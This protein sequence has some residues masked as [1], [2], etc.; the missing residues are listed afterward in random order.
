MSYYDIYM[1]SPDP[2]HYYDMPEFPTEAI[3]QRALEQSPLHVNFSE[4]WWNVIFEAARDAAKSD[5]TSLA[6]IVRTRMAV[7][8]SEDPKIATY[9]RRAIRGIEFD[10]AQD[11][12]RKAA[13]EQ[14]GGIDED[15]ITGAISDVRTIEARRIAFQREGEEGQ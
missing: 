13:L 2:N 6:E 7:G 3:R 14:P 5:E 8:F 10:E 12:M 1:A 15:F 11:L 4:F 9:K